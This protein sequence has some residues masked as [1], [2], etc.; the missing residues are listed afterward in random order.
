[1]LQGVAG[2]GLSSA[3]DPAVFVMTSYNAPWDREG[4]R[5]EV[6]LRKYEVG[7]EQW[8]GPWEKE[9]MRIQRRLE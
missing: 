3:S 2:E 8:A 9:D 1:M 6:M 7:G 5:E 4:R